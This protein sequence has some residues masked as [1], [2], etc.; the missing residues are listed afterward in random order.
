MSNLAELQ[1]FIYSDIRSLTCEAP[2]LLETKSFWRLSL[3]DSWKAYGLLDISS[4]QTNITI[5]ELA[6]LLLDA[7]YRKMITATLTT[8][9]FSS[10]A[11]RLIWWYQVCLSYSE[12]KRERVHLK[13]VFIICDIVTLAISGLRA[14]VM[15]YWCSDC[16]YNRPRW[17]NPESVNSLCSFLVSAI[18]GKQFGVKNSDTAPLL[19]DTLPDLVEVACDTCNVKNLMI[20]GVQTGIL[21]PVVALFLLDIKKWPFVRG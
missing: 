13:V 3:P 5:S 11:C 21:M 16:Y 1:L 8:R 7:D 18:S 12:R 20:S 14:Y 2:F 4:R 9:Q 15:T 6:P 17:F 19:L 10:V